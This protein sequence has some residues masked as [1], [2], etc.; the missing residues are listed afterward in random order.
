ML[1]SKYYSICSL[2]PLIFKEQCTNKLELTSNPKTRREAA[3]E[4]FF[5]LLNKYWKFKL[6]VELFVVGVLGDEKLDMNIVDLQPKRPT[7]SWPASKEAPK[8]LVSCTSPFWKPH[9]QYCVQAW[10]LQLGKDAE[11]L[12]WIQRRSQRWS[13][14]WSASPVNKGWSSWVW[15]VWGREG[16]FRE[17]SLKPSSTW[18]EFT[19]RRETNF[20]HGL[21]MTGL[22]REQY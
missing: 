16:F 6:Y 5:H 1:R 20:L 17:T 3:T 11:L 14:S 10:G 22:G 8:G 19:N 13:D 18:R 9:V 7:A 4:A 21:I 2:S 12:E 15:L